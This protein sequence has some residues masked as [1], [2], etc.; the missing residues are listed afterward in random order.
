MIAAIVAIDSNWGIGR[1]GDLLVNIPKDKKFFKEITDG[2]TVI[3]G[4]KTW[5]SLPKKPLPNRINYI[6][7]RSE[8]CNNDSVKY[9]SLIEAIEMIKNTSKNE[10]V[11]VIGGGQIYRE[12]LPYCDTVYLTKIYG[13]FEADT[14]FPNINKMK[15][16]KITD[17]SETEF[18]DGILPYQFV[19]Y[20]KIQE[21]S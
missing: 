2:S 17:Y 7:S 18:V 12:L 13:N 20:E 19:K 3:M 4:R 15:E 9:I 10:K 8:T 21:V 11:F 14:F 1:N 5:D 6:I 16:W